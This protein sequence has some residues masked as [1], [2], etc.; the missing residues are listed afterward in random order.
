MY[1]IGFES[2]YKTHPIEEKAKRHTINYRRGRAPD[3][4]DQSCTLSC[5]SIVVHISDSLSNWYKADCGLR[6]LSVQFAYIY[7]KQMGYLI[8]TDDKYFCIF[9]FAYFKQHIS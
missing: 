1:S 3:I 4:Y 9:V 5:C 8:S 7:I 2:K 6:G